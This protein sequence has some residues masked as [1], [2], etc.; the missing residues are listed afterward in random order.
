MII[1]IR[2]WRE[3]VIDCLIT[4]MPMKQNHNR[5]LWSLKNV[6]IL[7]VKFLNLWSCLALMEK[8]SMVTLKLPAAYLERNINKKKFSF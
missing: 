1:F 2:Y 7:D 3:F 5:V 8:V 4:E 6:T